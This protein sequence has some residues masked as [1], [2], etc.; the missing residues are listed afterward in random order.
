MDEYG[1]E[2]DPF[3]EL[4][5]GFLQFL[6]VTFHANMNEIGIFDCDIQLTQLIIDKNLL[7]KLLTRENSAQRSTPQAQTYSHPF[8]NRANKQ[9]TDPF[10]PQFRTLGNA[11]LGGTMGDPAGTQELTQANA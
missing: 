5:N 8:R 3:H 2:E 7:D 6:Q 11:S 9:V 4:I 10:A 1:E